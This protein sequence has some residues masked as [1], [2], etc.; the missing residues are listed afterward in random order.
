MVALNR[1][2]A[3]PYESFGAM[4]ARFPQAVAVPIDP[5]S[6]PTDAAAAASHAFRDREGRLYCVTLDDYRKRHNGC[7]LHL[8]VSG[9]GVTAT[10]A[11]VFYNADRAYLRAAETGVHR[12]KVGGR[13]IALK[14]MTLW[15]FSRICP[16][17]LPDDSDFRVAVD[18]KCPHLFNLLAK[19][20]A[21]WG[22]TAPEVS[23]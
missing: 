11:E 2:I 9:P 18:R 10:V 20:P 3:A 6:S 21:G 16:W 23:Q 22:S 5:E 7:W 19:V 17:A 8:S 12:R 1:P 14:A 4:R 13:E 15:F